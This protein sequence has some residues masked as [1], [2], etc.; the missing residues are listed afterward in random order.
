MIEVKIY[1]QNGKETG[2]ITL[3]EGVFGLSWNN[4]LVYQVVRAMEANARTPVAHTKGRGDVR[5]GG[6]KP[7]KQKGTGQARHGSIRSPIWIG[8]GITHGP[9][10]E[11]IYT[12]KINK[13]MRVK[14]LAVALSS[15]LR[16][17]ELLFVDTISVPD[18]KTA[19]AREILRALSGV[20]GFEG[21]VGKKSNATLLALGARDEKTI[22]SFRNFGN[23]CAEETRNLNPVDVLRY[24]YL[25][26]ERPTESVA[27]LEKRIGSIKEN[28]ST[29]GSPLS[30]REE[31][32]SKS[33]VRTK[34]KR[35]VSEKV[36][37]ITA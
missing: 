25:V 19:K 23:V 36:K 22:R 29:N 20:K 1:N 27:F 8:G 5:G 24:K 32:T 15:K 12:Q 34:K 7:W 21:V 17:G 35:P 10:K 6:K 4:D 33:E 2:T 30:K 3:P 11:K 13:R 18:A 31:T 37:K 28:V 14:A 26:I 9:S 16:D